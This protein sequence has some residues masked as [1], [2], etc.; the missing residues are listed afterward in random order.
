VPLTGSRPILVSELNPALQIHTATFRVEG[1]CGV[2]VCSVQILCEG[3]GG[4]FGS[5]IINVSPETGDC[6]TQFTATW[7]S[8]GLTNTRLILDGIDQ[9]AVPPSGSQ[10]ITAPSAGTHT[11]KLVGTSNGAQTECTDTFVVSG[12]G[13]PPDCRMSVTPS[14]GPQGALFD[15]CFFASNASRVDVYVDGVLKCT[16]PN[17][18]PGVQYNCRFTGFSVGLGFHTAMI[19]ATGCGGTCSRSLPFLVHADKVDDTSGPPA[20][21]PPLAPKLL[22]SGTSLPF[23]SRDL[24]STS[25]V[26]QVLISNTGTAPL[27]ISSIVI[28]GDNPGD[29]AIMGGGPGL[30]QPGTTRL[31]DLTFTPTQPGPRSATLHITSN[32]AGSPHT[33]SLTGTGVSTVPAAPA[34]MLSTTSINFGSVMVNGSSVEMPI[35]VTNTGTAPLSIF[36]VTF[37]GAGTMDF[38]FTGGDSGPPLNPGQSR[39][40]T[41]QFTPKSGGALTARVDIITNASTSPD[42]V[43]LS[44]TGT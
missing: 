43:F 31:L 9:G 20:G 8:V 27:A 23:G 32:A 6:T 26:Q 21:Q 42:Q 17:P 16:Q 12:V 22:L 25:P 38:R 33:V 1:P 28:A 40:I 24:G 2:S 11:V 4:Q 19:V 5:C 35:V 13:G 44:G 41:V 15:I 39:T 37:G 10:V 36:N 29:F 34:V 3:T 7:T 14:A 30:L 18:V